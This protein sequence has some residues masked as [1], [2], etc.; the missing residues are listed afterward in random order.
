MLLMLCYQLYFGFWLKNKLYVQSRPRNFVGRCPTNISCR[1]KEVKVRGGK[2]PY[3]GNQWRL[4]ARWRGRAL[5]HVQLRPRNFVTL[6]SIRKNLCS[7]NFI[8]TMTDIQSFCDRYSVTHNKNQNAT[9]HTWHDMD[10]KNSNVGC[11]YK[12]CLTANVSW[13]NNDWRNSVAVTV[14]IQAVS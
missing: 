2:A 13:I 6:L 8:V 11:V 10:V 7:L 9:W 1:T 5:S 4:V 14:H 12:T 3:A